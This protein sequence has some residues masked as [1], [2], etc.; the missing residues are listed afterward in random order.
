MNR[1]ESVNM[2]AMVA[3]ALGRVDRAADLLG[4]GYSV[5]SGVHD[6]LSRLYNLLREPPMPGIDQLRAVA[7]GS[8]F[9]AEEG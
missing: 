6:V 9:A 7:L 2:Q 5:D 1:C 4:P 8:E 3:C